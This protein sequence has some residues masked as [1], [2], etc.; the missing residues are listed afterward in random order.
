[1][2]RMLA[3]QALAFNAVSYDFLNHQGWFVD[4]SSSHESVMTVLRHGA[5]Y[6]FSHTFTLL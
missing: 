6:D 1:M 3:F 2:A 4:G 5:H